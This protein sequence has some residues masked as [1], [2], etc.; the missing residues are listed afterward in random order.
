MTRHAWVL[1][2]RVRVNQGHVRSCLGL[3]G[4]DLHLPVKYLFFLSWNVMSRI[5]FICYHRRSVINKVL[6]L[7]SKNLHQFLPVFCLLLC[8]EFFFFLMNLIKI[9]YSVHSPFLLPACT[10]SLKSSLPI[11]LWVFSI[12]KACH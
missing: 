9:H 11:S 3:E 8:L 5:T 7:N 1:Y 6:V 4:S 2:I 12:T 10:I